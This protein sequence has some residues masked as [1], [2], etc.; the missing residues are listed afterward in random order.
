MADLSPVSAAVHLLSGRAREGASGEAINAGQALAYDESDGKWY[1]ADNN[2]A[3]SARKA[4]HGISLTTVASAGRPIKIQT[5]GTI[6]LGCV[7]TVGGIYVVSATAGAICP[8]ADLAVGN[9]VLIIG[10]GGNP[11]GELRQYSITLFCKDTG[12]AHP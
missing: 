8:E 10:P 6:Y 11:A 4:I 7:V 5:Q 9:D 3:T 1:L 2:S 12:V